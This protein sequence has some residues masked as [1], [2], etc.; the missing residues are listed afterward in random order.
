MKKSFFLPL[1]LM[2][3]L[4][5]C[6]DNNGVKGYNLLN[7]EQAKNFSVSSYIYE[8][9]YDPTI[10][11]FLPPYCIL[12]ADSFRCKAQYYPDNKKCLS[13]DYYY[14]I[15]YPYIS[16]YNISGLYGWKIDKDGAWFVGYLTKDELEIEGIAGVL[17]FTRDTSMIVVD[18]SYCDFE[19]FNQEEPMEICTYKVEGDPNSL[20]PIQD[21]Q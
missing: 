1:L 7:E 8:T 2:L 18:K 21:I 17:R 16:L 3:A 6:E 4:V 15:D 11:N 10:E 12:F 20:F 14:E 19:F 13:K 9:L 5:G